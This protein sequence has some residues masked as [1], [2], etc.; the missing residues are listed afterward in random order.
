MKA[1]ITA[2]QVS[3]YHGYDEVM[4]DDLPQP[5]VLIANKGHDPDAIREVVDC[6]GGTPVI[7]ARRTRNTLEPMDGF[8]YVHRN[9]VERR[10]IKLK[11]RPTRGNP[12]R[13][14]HSEL[15]RFHLHRLG[16]P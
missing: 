12:L 5:K 11:K 8:I 3:D 16:Q 1:G 13:Q 2:G 10:I 15:S 14:D 9:L 4:D 6:R 7:P